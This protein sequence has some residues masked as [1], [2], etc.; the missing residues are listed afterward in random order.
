LRTAALEGIKTKQPMINSN[1]ND[2]LS[3]RATVA[4]SL[5]CVTR[6]GGV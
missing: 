2:R 5:L 6:L 4:V 1:N 3:A